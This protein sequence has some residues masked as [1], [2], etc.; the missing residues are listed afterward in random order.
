MGAREALDLQLRRARLSAPDRSLAT[1]L[2]YGVTRRRLSLDHE[3]DR[4]TAGRRL[5]AALRAALRLGL[6][7]LR[8]LG[9]VPSYAVLNET[10]ELARRYGHEGT[11]R[12]A[13]A[14]LRRALAE[15][16]PEPPSLAV[17][18]SHPEWL[19]R[20]WVERLGEEEARALLEADN[21]VPP[22]AVRVNRL[23][24]SPEALAR[25]LA[26][27]GAKVRPGRW[28]PEALHVVS[29]PPPSELKAFR[30]GMFTIQGEASMLAALALDPRPGELVLDVAAAPGGKA[31]HVAERMGDRGQVVANEVEPRRARQVEAAVRRLGLRSVA[32]RQ[33]D[34]RTLPE[35]FA[36]RCDRVLADLPCS[37]LGVLA[38]RPDLR[39]RKVEPDLPRLGALQA[40]LLDAAAAC[41]R[42]GGAL[43]FSTCSTEP[44]EG[45]E[46]VRA[47]LAG[48]PEFEASPLGPRLPPGL[49]GAGPTLRLWPHRHGTDGFFLARFERRA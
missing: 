19:V 38:R 49:D 41:V 14:V 2:V 25:A 36:G 31:T 3:I 7:Q 20:R 35:A 27:E 34:A 1:E 21:A 43:L 6:Y 9:R 37:G 42:P 28:C 23:R 47:F 22:A 18:S 10:V 39:W 24:T 11:A 48:H 33:G 46:V 8:H 44:E 40:E 45:E 26:A 30:R 15:G 4:L 16:P 13:N 29:G 12:L 5:E 17:A 32:I